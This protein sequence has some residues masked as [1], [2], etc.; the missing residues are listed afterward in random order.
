MSA[1]DVDWP[2]VLFGTA[3]AIVLGLGGFAIVHTILHPC[4]RYDTFACTEKECT[5][6]YQTPM[7]MPDGNGGTITYWNT[8]CGAWREYA[9]TCRT[10][11]EYK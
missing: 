11:A 5:H 9:S 4:I 2:P 3:L 7:I 8:E 1:R 10:C 6:E